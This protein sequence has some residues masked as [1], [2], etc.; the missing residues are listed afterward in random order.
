MSW[1]QR[2][3]D[4]RLVR[5]VQ[6]RREVLRG[7]LP[8]EG[9]QY[10]DETFGP[11]RFMAHPATMSLFILVIFIL[12]LTAATFYYAQ[13]SGALRWLIFAAVV[14]AFG[15]AAVRIVASRAR[16][17]ARG[18]GRAATAPRVGGDLRSRRTTLER[19][20][21]GLVYSQ[22]VFEDRVRRAF[23]EKVRANRHLDAAAIDASARDLERLQSILGDKELALFVLETARNMRVYPASVPTLPKKEQFARRTAALLDRMEAWR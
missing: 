20:Q 11:A 7:P 1:L 4:E 3:A 12:L 19:A 18:P 10:G 14:A 5:A 13:Y 21:G 16:D 9:S 17:P 8:R 6:M 22:L 15:Y 23:L 2:G